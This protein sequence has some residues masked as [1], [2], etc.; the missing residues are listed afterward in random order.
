MS[1]ETKQNISAQK[2]ARSAM[3]RVEQLEQIVPQIIRATQQTQAQFSQSIEILDAVVQILGPE[4]VEKAIAEN[5]RERAKLTVADQ[6]KKL[7][8]DLA[9]GALVKVDSITENSLI[10]FSESTPDGKPLDPDRTQLNFSTL[11]PQF[12]EELLLKGPG[13]KIT[14]PNGNTFEVMEVYDVV[15]EDQR[16]KPVEAPAAAEAPKDLDLEAAP[17]GS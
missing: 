2:A 11:V 6:L 8:E 7:E 14:S 17:E 3:Q 15:P 4:A 1:Q 10:V 5:R 13:A 9:S 12:K 16:P